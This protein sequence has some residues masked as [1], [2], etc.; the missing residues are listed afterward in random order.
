MDWNMINGTEWLPALIGSLCRLHKPQ[1]SC[2]MCILLKA[3]EGN[4][5]G[6]HIWYS[7]SNCGKIY[8]NSS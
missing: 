4:S 1:L 7:V 5:L 2:L 6:F 3:G 8:A